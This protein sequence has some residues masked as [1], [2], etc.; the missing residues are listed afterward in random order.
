[1]ETVQLT[2]A[3][4]SKLDAFQMKGLRKLLG[5]KHTYWDRSATNESIMET[6][7]WIARA[8]N[9]TRKQRNNINENRQGTS[10]PLQDQKKQRGH[11]VGD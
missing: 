8:S 6:A 3:M 11:Q 7:T 2:E 9:K 10:A 4:I 1:M 5:K